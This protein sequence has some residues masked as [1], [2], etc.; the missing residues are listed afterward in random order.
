MDLC[1]RLEAAKGPARQK[2]YERILRFVYRT[3]R[4]RMVNGRW[5]FIEAPAPGIKAIAEKDLPAEWKADKPYTNA[6]IS[7][8]LSE[9]LERPHSTSQLK[10]AQPPAA[11]SRPTTRPR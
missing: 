6:E 10:L 9:A 1:R 2:L 8:L 4:T 11:A 5:L 7:D 3:R